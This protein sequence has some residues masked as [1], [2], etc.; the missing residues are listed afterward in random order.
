MWHLLAMTVKHRNVCCKELLQIK[1]LLKMSK[2]TC[3]Q[4]LLKTEVQKSNRIQAVNIRCHFQKWG[5]NT[6]STWNISGA[7]C[8]CEM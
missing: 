6:P 3:T 7:L 2:I 8:E 1:I 4:T 5:V